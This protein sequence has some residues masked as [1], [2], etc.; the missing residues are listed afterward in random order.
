MIDPYYEPAIDPTRYVQLGC[1]W[2]LW[3]LQ[4]L[5][6][7]NTEAVQLKLAREIML[8]DKNVPAEAEEAEEG[9]EVD[10]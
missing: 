10:A 2:R 5:N 9:E 7:Q 3:I 6:A 8:R 1:A 4:M